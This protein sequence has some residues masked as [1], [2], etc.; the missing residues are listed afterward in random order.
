MLSG[1]T[2]VGR[3][4]LQAVHV[5]EQVALQTEQ[6]LAAQPSRQEPSAVDAVRQ[7]MC[8]GMVRIAEELKAALVLVASRQGRTARVLSK[9]RSFVPTVSVSDSPQA[10]RR[11]CLYWGVVPLFAT[12]IHEPPALLARVVAWAREHGMVRP[13]DHVVFLTTSQW[14]GAGDEMILVHRVAE[15]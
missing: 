13:A 9:Q 3:Y 8:H 7:A 10:V 4:P 11:M 5:I 2:A 14:A 1:E 12:D 15:P 6:R